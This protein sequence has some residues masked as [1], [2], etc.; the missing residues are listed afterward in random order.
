MF[1]PNYVITQTA[2][3]AVPEAARVVLSIIY[4]AMLLYH[5]M[6]PLGASVLTIKSNSF[7]FFVA[8][9]RKWA[10]TCTRTDNRSAVNKLTQVTNYES[11]IDQ[12]LGIVFLY[13]IQGKQN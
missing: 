7:A 12:R 5:N 3:G 4:V 9:M 6:S 8:I 11:F 1:Y 2:D 10:E 13:R